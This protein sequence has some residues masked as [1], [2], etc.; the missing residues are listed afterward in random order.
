M[1]FEVW[2]QAVDREFMRLFRI[3]HIL[4][5]FSDEEMIADWRAG[6]AP[7][8]WVVRI[9]EKYDLDLGEDSSRL[10]WS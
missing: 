10:G 9:G 2:L 6:E 7:A 4:G 1:E 8:D 5:G 3:D